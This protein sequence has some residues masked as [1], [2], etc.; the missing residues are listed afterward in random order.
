MGKRPV[1]ETGELEGIS[2]QI[3]LGAGTTVLT[4]R[5]GAQAPR[6]RAPRSSGLDRG[7]NRGD[8]FPGFGK[9]VA[10]SGQRLDHLQVTPSTPAVTSHSRASWP[11]SSRTILPAVFLPTP[12]TRLKAATSSVA[13]AV[14]RSWDVNMDSTLRANRGPTPV[15]P[16]RDSKLI[17]E[18]SDVQNRRG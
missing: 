7:G 5:R 6:E 14:A 15:M 18:S 10:Q 3:I 17:L 12:G 11:F 13:T 9:R 1:P 4:R 16:S 8:R 2:A